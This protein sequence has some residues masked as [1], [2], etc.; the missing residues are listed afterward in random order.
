MSTTPRTGT[1][2]GGRRWARWQRALPAALVAVLVMAVPLM[3]TPGGEETAPG[4]ETVV[5]LHGLGRTAASMRPVERA[6]EAEGYRVVNLGYPSRERP[7]SEL[8][9]TLAAALDLCCARDSSVH[10]VTHSLGGIVVRAYAHRHGAARIGRVVMLSPPNAGS[11][12]VDR[13]GGVPPVEWLLGP[14]FVQLGTDSAGIAAR[15]GPPAF[16]AGVITGDASLNPLLSRWLPGEDDG[17]VSVESARLEGAEDFLVVPYSHTFIM[18]KEEVIAQVVAFL[19]T[20][21]FLDAG[22]D[23]V[24]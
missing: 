20:G 22:R 18:R 21:R 7:V 15:L 6:L 5:L 24:R 13:L 9:D 4:E 1:P 12:V 16:E 23:T 10:F 8:V 17:K 19:R 11:E 3:P 14:A 2:G